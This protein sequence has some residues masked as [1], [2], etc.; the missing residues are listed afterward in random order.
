[1]I[2]DYL[3]ND[4]ATLKKCTLVC[5][6]WLPTTALHLW[7]NGSITLR[8]R[9]GD[10]TVEEFLACLSGSRIL[11]PF[12][13]RELHINGRIPKCSENYTVISEHAVASIL[14]KLCPY[15]QA[16]SLSNLTLSHSND[17]LISQAT[18][19]DAFST[20]KGLRSLSIEYCRDDLRRP[21]T[22][23]VTPEPGSP[24]A[25]VYSQLEQ[26]TVDA[27][28][29]KYGRFS[30][31]AASI[32]DCLTEGSKLRS[33]HFPLRYNGHEPESRQNLDTCGR[34][35]AAVGPTLEHLTLDTWQVDDSRDMATS[36][37]PCTWSDLEHVNSL[38][39]A[40]ISLQTSSSF[41]PG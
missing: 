9:P 32:Y 18:L 15:I 4:R 22:V 34:L 14:I 33:I 40:T 35:L 21:D 30:S 28:S 5:K 39:Q 29:V 6:S 13:L 8:P 16:F 41:S 36:G 25:A 17:P 20:V 38:T 7:P 27:C 37:V 12:A 1:M 26:L 19:Q 2:L 3:H 10:D 23:A 24:T 31:L 11:I